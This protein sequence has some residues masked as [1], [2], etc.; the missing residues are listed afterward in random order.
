MWLRDNVF[1]AK[2]TYD[3]L[4]ALVA[5]QALNI[6]ELEATITQL[7]AEVTELKRRLGQNF[8]GNPHCRRRRIRWNGRPH[9]ASRPRPVASPG[10][11]TQPDAP[12]AVGDQ[13]EEG[14]VGDPP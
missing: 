9:A 2:S 12:A 10:N 3:E 14:P 4:A 11:K 5:A 6:Q 8:P 13:G 7:R 1:V